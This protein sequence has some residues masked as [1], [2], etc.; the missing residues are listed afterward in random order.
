MCGQKTG[1]RRFWR[2]RR[3]IVDVDTNVEQ[4]GPGIGDAPDVASD[5]RTVGTPVQEA[6]AASV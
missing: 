3:G 6:R 1:P 4:T 5:I 2:A